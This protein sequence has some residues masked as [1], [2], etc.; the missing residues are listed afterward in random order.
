M[1][2]MWI[3]SLG[4]LVCKGNLPGQASEQRNK[5]EF[6]GVE[7]FCGKVASV[8][9]A[10]RNPLLAFDAGVLYGEEVL[11]HAAL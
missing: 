9:G 6:I 2:K 3:I 5:H 11:R 10:Y 7:H 8:K 4:K 1:R